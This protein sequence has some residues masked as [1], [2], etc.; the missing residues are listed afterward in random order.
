MEKKKLVPEG[1]FTDAD[2]F[3]IRY[4]ATEYLKA[5]GENPYPHKFHATISLQD[6][7]K[8]YSYLKSGQILKDNVLS[9]AGRV[10]SKR[11][12]GA[13]LIFYDLKLEGEVLQIISDSAFY[14]NEDEFL[15]TNR[16]IRRGDV[17]GCK[18]YP[19]RSKMGELSLKT[20]Y[21]QTLAPCLHKFPHPY[22]GLLDSDKN[23]ILNIW[24]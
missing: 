22:F 19:Y 9:L 14:P 24:K 6:F 3:K 16:K 23:F 13:K 17:I 11:K 18:G 12:S 10:I 8:H 5:S 15:E 21:I 1:Y 2:Y 7:N 4:Q 20:T